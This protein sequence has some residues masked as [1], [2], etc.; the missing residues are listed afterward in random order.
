MSGCHWP[1]PLTSQRT[2]E[3]ENCNVFPRTYCPQEH[4][5]KAETDLINSAGPE[6]MGALF[7]AQK[8]TRTV[9]TGA[10]G[11]KNTCTIQLGS[12]VSPTTNL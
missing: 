6:S 10:T 12:N 2:N 11:Q 7:P 1:T 4:A 9:T 8:E 3:T 5:K